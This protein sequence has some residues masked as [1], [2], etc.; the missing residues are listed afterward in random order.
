VKLNINHITLNVI[1]GV[2]EFEQQA[3]QSVRVDVAY[4]FFDYLAACQTDN[5]ADTICYATVAEKLQS[6]CNRKKYQLVEHLAWELSEVLVKD[7]EM[8]ADIKVTVYK[9]APVDNIHQC[10]VEI[11]RHYAT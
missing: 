8:A 5:L 1:L 7:L 6:V 2:Y 4:Y 9:E 10:I 11:E 3:P